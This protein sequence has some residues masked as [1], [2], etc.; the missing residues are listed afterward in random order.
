M[1]LL[2]FWCLKYRGVFNKSWQTATLARCFTWIKKPKFNDVC[3]LFKHWN[4]LLLLRKAGNPFYEVQMS[5][6]FGEV[7]SGQ[8]TGLPL[9]ETHAVITSRFLLC[10]LQSFCSLLKTLLKT[11]IQSLTRARF[12]LKGIALDSW[13]IK[14]IIGSGF[15]LLLSYMQMH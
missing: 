6:I 13:W 4:F 12:T 10:L 15:V 1:K 9:I 2:T 14:N 8:A 7:C 5:N 3:V 11:L